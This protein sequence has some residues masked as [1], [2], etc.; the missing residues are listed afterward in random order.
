[1]SIFQQRSILCFD[2][3][4]KHKLFPATFGSA[5]KYFLCRPS[6][7]QGTFSLAEKYLPPSL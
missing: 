3:P 7:Q 6:G 1:M 2:I 5:E 4:S